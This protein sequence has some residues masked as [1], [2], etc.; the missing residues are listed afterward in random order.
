[1]RIEKSPSINLLNNACKYTNAGGTVQLKLSIQAHQGLI[2]VIDSG[3]GISAAHLPHIFQRFYRGNEVHTKARGGFG[4]GLAIAEQIVKAHNGQIIVT[5]K[6][7]QGS[8]SQI[9]LPLSSKS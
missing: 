9:R 5:S 8:T 6:L 7:G 2:Q 3:V 4:L 1:M